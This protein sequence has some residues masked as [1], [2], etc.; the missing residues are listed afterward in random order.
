MNISRKDQIEFAKTLLPVL[1]SVAGPESL[2][3][4]HETAALVLKWS[5]HEDNGVAFDL[6]EYTFELAEIAKG[7]ED[8]GW[9]DEAKKRLYSQL[10]PNR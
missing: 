1:D 8:T 5:G 6:S 2:A 7:K 10:G 9:K 4:L 3:H